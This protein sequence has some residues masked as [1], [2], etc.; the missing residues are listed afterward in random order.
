MKKSWQT[1]FNPRSPCGERR[2]PDKGERPEYD[3]NPRSPCGERLVQDLNFALEQLEFQ[4]TLPVWGATHHDELVQ[5]AVQISIHA[6]RVGSDGFLLP[7]SIPQLHFNPR[8]PCGER[9]AARAG[10][11]Q[12][13]HFNP[14]S[15]CG[16]RRRRGSRSCGGRQFQSTLPVWGATSKYFFDNW[17]RRISI[18][19]PRV[20]SDRFPGCDFLVSSHFN[21]RSPCGERPRTAAD[22]PLTAAFQSTLPV[23]GATDGS[24]P[25]RAIKKISIHAPRVGSDISCL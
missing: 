1:Y 17:G 4:S 20:G 23:W 21:P 7:G 22:L 13:K 16:E 15:P 2:Q 24:L 19:A 25:R 3:F 6:P 9:R 14:R 11:V 10:G 18:H 8:S 5:T 12:Q